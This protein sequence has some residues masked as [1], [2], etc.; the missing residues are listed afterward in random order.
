MVVA[1][2]G[3]DGADTDA[4]DEGEASGVDGDGEGG[5]DV[6]D[7]GTDGVCEDAASLVAVA[8]R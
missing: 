8:E 6:R 7:G 3:G 5:S 4:D 2:D 1:A